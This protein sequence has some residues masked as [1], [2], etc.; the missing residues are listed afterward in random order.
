[1]LYIINSRSVLYVNYKKERNC[2]E[3]NS[4]FHILLSRKGGT[5]KKNK[6]I[7]TKCIFFFFLYI[8]R[9]IILIYVSIYNLIVFC[10]LFF[11]CL[12]FCLNKFH[13]IH[14]YHSKFSKNE[15]KKKLNKCLNS[16]KEGR[17]SI[18]TV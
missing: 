8:F 3:S 17:K 2:L 5:K 15:T 10:V 14:N 16:L 11:C 13:V 4:W 18:N 12:S 7:V 1:M 9:I 6:I